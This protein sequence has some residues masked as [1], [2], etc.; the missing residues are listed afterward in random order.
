MGAI[1]ASFVQQSE[2]QLR[3]EWPQTETD[4]PAASIFPPSFSASSISTP[5]SSAAGVTLKAIM[6]Q[7]QRMDARLDHLTDEMCQMNTHAGRIA[8]RQARLG[9]FAPSPSLSLEA[10][11]KDDDAGDDKDDASSSSDDEMTTSQ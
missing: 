5:S 4:D 7:L 3:L 9:G 6:A 1:I 11:N 10:A 8:R 2:A